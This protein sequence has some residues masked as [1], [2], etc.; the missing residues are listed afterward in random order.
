MTGVASVRGARWAELVVLQLVLCWPSQWS[1][2]P[3]AMIKA[4]RWVDD[5]SAT[6]V[7][8]DL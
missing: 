4:A 1:R 3:K 5:I 7:P 2:S 6:T 8:F